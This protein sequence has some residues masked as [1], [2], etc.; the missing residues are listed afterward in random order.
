[1][2]PEVEESEPVQESN[3]DIELDAATDTQPEPDQTVDEASKEDVEESAQGIQDVAVNN[4]V[5]EI[6]EAPSENDTGEASEIDEKPVEVDTVEA[7][8]YVHI[9][10]ASQRWNYEML[11]VCDGVRLI[12]SLLKPLLIRHRKWHCLLLRDGAKLTTGTI[13]RR[14]LR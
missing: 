6:K 9:T 8:P 11:T 5:E 10:P 1:M 2:Q 13:V 14:K 7:T 4:P 3:A 12:R